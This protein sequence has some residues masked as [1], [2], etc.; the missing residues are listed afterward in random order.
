MLNGCL[1]GKAW[2][3]WPDVVTR[4]FPDSTWGAN[5]GVDSCSWCSRVMAHRWNVE[6]QNSPSIHL[7]MLFSWSMAQMAQHHHSTSWRTRDHAMYFWA[8]EFCKLHKNGWN[9]GAWILY[10]SELSWQKPQVHWVWTAMMTWTW[11]CDMRKLGLHAPETKTQTHQDLTFSRNNIRNS[12]S[13]GIS[14]ANCI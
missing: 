11:I 10:G 4:W 8:L 3:D 12:V 14:S 5:S 9:D 6:G 2:V 7:T 13:D 1:Y